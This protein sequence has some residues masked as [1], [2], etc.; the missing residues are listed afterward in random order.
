MAGELDRV[1]EG[2]PVVDLFDLEGKKV[3]VKNWAGK[4]KL[5]VFLRH[6]G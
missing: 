5:L 6:L 3:D 4:W 1:G 2:L